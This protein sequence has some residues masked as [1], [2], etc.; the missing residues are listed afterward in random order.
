MIKKRIKS[1]DAFM[2][3]T[4][5]LSVV[6]VFLI[7][8]SFFPGFFADFFGPQHILFYILV[9]LISSGSGLLPD[10]DNTRSTAISVLGPIGSVIS[11]TMRMTARVIYS[12][13]RSKMDKPSADPHRGFWHTIVAA[14]GFGGI[15]WGLVKICTRFTFSIF[16]IKT[17]AG[18]V[19]IFVYALICTQ[20]V[21]AVFFKRF[22]KR[23]S[24]GF[25]G[26]L[27]L[28]II[29]FLLTLVLML[30]LPEITRY[31]WFW[32]AISGGWIIHI[33]GDTLTTSGTPLFWPIK[34]K[35][36]RWWS[37]RWPPYI[38][39]NGPIEHYIFIPFFL[40]IIAISLLNILF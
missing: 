19:V 2:G 25:L 10:F 37:Y 18:F 24:N 27:S 26:K 23:I 3:P 33:L 29:G 40:L 16:S 15:M 31:G 4:H 8:I 9:L 22:S 28:W 12:L 35:G 11:N 20:L 14:V 17:N 6:A 30:N 32:I 1:D 21:L 13:T 36:H 39:A 34:H 7:I 38:R 5:A